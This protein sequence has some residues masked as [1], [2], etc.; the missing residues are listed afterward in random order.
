VEPGCDVFLSYAHSHADRAK[1]ILVAG[2]PRIGSNERVGDKVTIPAVGQLCA[3]YSSSTPSA[4]IVD[5]HRNMRT[6][7]R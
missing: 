2:A 1:P 7:A 4:N 3:V 6:R 5:A